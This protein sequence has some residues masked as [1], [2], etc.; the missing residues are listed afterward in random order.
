MVWGGVAYP[1]HLRPRAIR[2]DLSRSKP[3]DMSSSVQ[4]NADRSRCAPEC[5]AIALPVSF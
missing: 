4:E 1:P 2:A 5:F 3:R